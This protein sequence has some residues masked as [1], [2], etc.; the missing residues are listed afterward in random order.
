M[1]PTAPRTLPAVLLVMAVAALARPAAAEPVTAEEDHAR[2]MRQLGIESLRR[3]ADGDPASPHAANY[4]EALAGAHMASLPEPLVMD[5]GTPVET[6]AVW[7]QQRRPE[8]AAHFERE[9]YGRVPGELPPVH[10]TA[11]STADEE[12]GGVAV[13]VREL[14]G[15]VRANDGAGPAMNIRLT[16]TRPTTPAGE[17]PVVLELA[18]DPEFLARLRERFTEEQ[19]EAFSGGGPPWREQ[20]LGRGW[21]TAEL[22]ATSVQAD[23]GAGLYQGIIGIGTAGKPRQPDDW[24]ALRAWAWGASR[25]VDYLDSASGFDAGRVAIEGHSR[26]G[27]AMLVA[28]AFDRRI[29]V[30]FISSSGEGGAKLWRRHYGEQIGNI[31]G[32][33]EY[34]WVAGNFLKYA[35]PLGADDLPVDAHQLIALCAP[36]PV[37]ISSGTDGDE[38]TDPKGMFLA[39]AHASPVYELL[40]AKGLGTMDYPAV[41]TGLMDGELAWRQHPLGHTPAPN[42]PVF[43]D[44]AARYFESADS[45]RNGTDTPEREDSK[46]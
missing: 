11:T 9:I 6:A 19:L 39:A 32:T 18:L 26:Y 37:F 24:G 15:T 29:A 35:G 25:V 16:L 30:A 14:V 36:R 31:A 38:W 46:P 12:I 10:W 2:M 20:V 27:K 8:I 42:W 3:G 43:L 22:I 1:I 45:T 13:T 28:M 4:D 33:G 17:L 44:F 34:H 21:A 41:G 23:N 7:W 5:D 40:G